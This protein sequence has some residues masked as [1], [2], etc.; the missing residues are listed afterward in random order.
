MLPKGHTDYD[1]WDIL[2]F[3]S[4]NMQNICLLLTA[5]LL[6][7]NWHQKVLPKGHTDFV[8]SKGEILLFYNENK[9]NNSILIST[10]MA[11]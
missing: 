9:Q 10:I 3:Y 1:K 6:L 11:A 5:A 7:P 8:Q 2:L 4:I